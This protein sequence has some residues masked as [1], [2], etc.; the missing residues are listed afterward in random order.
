M[1]AV[2]TSMFVLSVI[3]RLP[4]PALIIAGI[5]GKTKEFAPEILSFLIISIVTIKNFNKMIYKK[6]TLGHVSAR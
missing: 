3:Y 6:K 5:N 1:A 4:A 2:P